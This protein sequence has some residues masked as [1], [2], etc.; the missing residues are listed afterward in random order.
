MQRHL[1]WKD[2]EAKINVCFCGHATVDSSAPKGGR[3][4]SRTRSRAGES[5]LEKM[6]IAKRKAFSGLV[7]LELMNLYTSE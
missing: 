3:Q 2:S 5:R 6:E 1:S 7:L 4:Y